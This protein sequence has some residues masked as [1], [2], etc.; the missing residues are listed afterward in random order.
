MIESARLERIRRVEMLAMTDSVC[1]DFLRLAL[2]A[3]SGKLR[4]TGVLAEA[5]R[6][7]LLIDLARAGRLNE[8]GPGAQVDT[9]PTGFGL[10][11]ELIRAVE[12]H[13]TRNL[14]IWM[15]RGVPHL[16]E[17]IAELVADG[18][19]TVERRDLTLAAHYRDSSAARYQALFEAIAAVVRGEH[20][21][22]DPR[23]AALAALATVT[24][25]VDPGPSLQH[26][27]PA[28]L[29]ASGDLRWI[30]TQVT[31]FLLDAQA[32]D[33]A[34]GAANTITTGIQLGSI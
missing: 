11:D 4:H 1:G 32:E 28:L 15:Q 14:R 7:A 16:H 33:G 30:T 2:D 6:G 21:P 9:T 24:S 17:F 13:P 31:D 26:P 12:E 8:N 29:E 18:F 10:A 5:M 3:D 25:L 27:S 23:Q 20:A 19:W 34:A 22:A